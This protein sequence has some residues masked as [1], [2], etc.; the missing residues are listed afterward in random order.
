MQVL[1]NIGDKGLVS[2]AL[3]CTRLQELRVFPLRP[4]IGANP[5]LTAEGLIALSMG[6]P[7]LHSL[8]YC[9]K[10]MTNAALIAVA[11]NCHNFIKFKLCI[12]D[13]KLPDGTT[14]QPFDE[15]FGAIVQSSKGL[16]R[17]SLSGLLSDQVFLYIGMYGEQLEML[18]IG[19]SGEG[20]KGLSYVLNGCR[21]L[22]KLEIKG[23]PFV[24]AALLVEIVKH[25]KIRCLWISS[26]KVTLGACRSLLMQVPMMNIEIIDE[27][28]NNSKKK[29]KDNDLTVGKMYLYRTFSG[30]RKDA[31]SS[32]WTL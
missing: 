6:C 5:A 28:N 30:P 22:K 24:D 12:S 10:H 26:S 20:G 19:S 4:Q 17:L 29:K 27:N 7:L 14:S 13:S 32:V 25:E 16:K 9:C 8:V 3:T 31:P 18:S 11:R 1:D 23:S 2:V 21:N 15:G